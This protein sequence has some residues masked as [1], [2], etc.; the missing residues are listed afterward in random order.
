MVLDEPVP[1]WK[2]IKKLIGQNLTRVS[3]PIIMN[4]P[5]SAL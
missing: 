3:L 4:E 5:I 1:I 2:I